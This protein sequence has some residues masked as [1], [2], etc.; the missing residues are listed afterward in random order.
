MLVGATVVGALVLARLV[1][2]LVVGALVVGALVVGALVVGA[3]VVGVRVVGVWVVGAC[4]GSEVAQEQSR[5]NDL[6]VA[7]SKTMQ[8]DSSCGT[9]RHRSPSLFFSFYNSSDNN[10]SES[11]N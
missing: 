6:H 9:V 10:G 8:S 7:C 4:V 1:G 5:P 2:A 11:I 3:L